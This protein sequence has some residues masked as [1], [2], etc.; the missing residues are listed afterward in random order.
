MR[1]VTNDFRINSKSKGLI[2]TYDVE[3]KVNEEDTKEETK[4]KT[5]KSLKASSTD[6]GSVDGELK[7]FQKFKIFKILDDQLKKIYSKYIFVGQN[8]FSAV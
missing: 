3:I 6:G 4:E 5:K 1:L 2:Y 7:T 8:L